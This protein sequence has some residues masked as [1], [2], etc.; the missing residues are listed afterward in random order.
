[1]PATVGPAF[2][3]ANPKLL[4]GDPPADECQ[5]GA[6]WEERARRARREI[7]ALAA[8]GLGVNDLHAAAIQM[9]GRDVG[10]ELTCWATLDPETLVISA[11]VSGET[12]VPPR[13]EPLLADAEYSAEEPNTFAA[14]ARSRKPLARLSDLPQHDQQRSARYTN[15][16]RPLGVNQ[17]L[18]ILFTSDGSCWG[19]AGM[20]RT[21]G[22]FSDREVEYLTSVAPTVAAATRLAVRT[23]LA[24]HTWGPRPAIVVLNS[25]GELRS[26]TPEARQ[27]QERLNEFAPD[28]FAVMMR[29][30]AHGL[31]SK[32]SE[33]F[34][35][36]IRDGQGQWALMEASPLDG[37][38]EDRIAVSISPATGS[39]LTGMLIA[40]Y[41]LSPRERAVCNEVLAGAPTRH[42]AKHLA[43]TPN[44]VQD[45]LKSV[46]A[47]TGVTSR[48]ELV[49]RLQ[50]R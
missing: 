2:G 49:A 18:R 39:W 20:V 17:E 45:H 3:R 13:F 4:G 40:A 43:V 16:W 44:T 27:W 29:I 50:P 38:E 23:E 35:A 19:A 46:F 48:G 36:T 21:G 1:M 22:D 8:S 33:G 41:G 37:D 9:T 28:R 25:G 24:S 12:R 30:M 11:M 26:I 42:I 5:T 32:P 47:K 15:V 7:A 34:R 31:R 14:M 6:V 10:T